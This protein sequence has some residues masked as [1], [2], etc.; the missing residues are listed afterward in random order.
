MS[1]ADT[2]STP[3]TNPFWTFSLGYYRSAGVS[4]SRR[5]RGWRGLAI[6]AVS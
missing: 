1:S 5:R 4:E 6:C 3:L 2:A